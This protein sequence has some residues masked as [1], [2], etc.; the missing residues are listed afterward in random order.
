MKKF[1]LFF[2]LIREQF[3]RIISEVRLNTAHYNIY[4]SLRMGKNAKCKPCSI[5]RSLELNYFC[6][7][8]VKKIVPLSQYTP[9]HGCY[10][11]Q[12]LS[13]STNQ[14][15]KALLLA[16][17]PIMIMTLIKFKKDTIRN[18]GGIAYTCNE[19][20]YV[21]ARIKE[22]KNRRLDGHR[23]QFSYKNAK[24]HEIM[25]LTSLKYIDEK[26]NLTLSPTTSFPWSSNNSK[27]QAIGPR[28]HGK[29]QSVNPSRDVGRVAFTRN[30]RTE[31]I[32]TSVLCVAF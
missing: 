18:V 2:Q 29:K 30:G 5:R 32:S 16:H 21:W 22:H 14:K 1:V 23:L 9:P 27:T 15:K 4:V 11:K 6:N 20:T 13:K 12:T 19:H 25:S 7:I 17:L 3:R 31:H 26:L 10:F 28:S 24:F 8:Q